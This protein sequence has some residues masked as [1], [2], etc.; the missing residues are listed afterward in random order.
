MLN[1]EWQP[2]GKDQTAGP[3]EPR[4]VDVNK[5][6]RRLRVR[7]IACPDKKLQAAYKVVIEELAAAQTADVVEAEKYND[8]RE[9][10]VDYVCSGTSNLAPYCQNRCGDCV[11][12]R[13][14]CISGTDKCRGFNP[15]GRGE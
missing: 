11:D 8:L 1:E 4:F 2:M 10:F 5:A 12:G 6:I 14:W 7:Q 15:D 9:A 3:T 13:G